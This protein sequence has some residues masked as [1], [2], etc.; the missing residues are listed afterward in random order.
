MSAKLLYFMHCKLT[1][2]T[3]VAYV[4]C[5]SQPLESLQIETYPRALHLA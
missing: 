1:H 3:V 4:D 2:A 5:I